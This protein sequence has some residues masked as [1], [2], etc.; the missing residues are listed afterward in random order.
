MHRD[1]ATWL[2]YW[3]ENVMGGT[4]YVF[5][6]ASSGFKGKSD[7]TKYEKARKLCKYIDKIRS[8]YIRNLDARELEQAC[9]A[10][11]DRLMRC[12]GWAAHAHPRAPA[13]SRRRCGSSTSW[14]S[15]WGTR[16]TRMRRTPSAPAPSASSTLPFSRPAP[17]SS[18]S[19]ARTPCA[20]TSALTCVQP[21]G[22]QAGGPV[23]PFPSPPP[24]SPQLSTYSPVGEK[25]FRNLKRFC[26]K[27]PAKAEIF[28]L[29]TVDMLNK[30]LSS[31]MPGLSGKVFRTYNAS[32]TLEQQLAEHAEEIKRAATSQEQKRVYDAANREVAIL[33]NH[34]RTVPKTHAA[35]VEKLQ[36]KVCARAHCAAFCADSG[37]AR[38]LPVQLDLLEEQL[39]E[40]QTIQKAV[41]RGKQVK[42]KKAKAEGEEV[43]RE[44]RAKEAH[45]F[46]R[47]PSVEQVSNKIA[48]WHKKIATT[49]SQ[50]MHK[51]RA[52]SPPPCRGRVRS[53]GADACG[54]VPR[55]KTRRWR[56]AHPRSTTWTP[57]SRWRGA[58]PMRCRW[59][60]SSPPL[61]ATSLAGPCPSIPHG[62][63][64]RSR[65]PWVGA[66]R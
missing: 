49:S 39:A 58:R 28:D 3:N 10:G 40:L 27:K 63:S 35:Q 38:L 15:V 52:A 17:S 7:Q 14:P 62:A 45:L 9:V 23:T 24:T 6:A 32:V 59:S 21:G 44:E 31:L 12:A 46:A 37:P 47:Q 13:N 65:Y 43:T 16:R 36:T 51:V 30:H 33:C 48:Q 34:Q 60:A 4:K 8:D 61:C 29:L 20:T 41:K 26:S 66:G 53:P 54:P 64:R 57:G 1:D 56:S 50:L 42:T 11:P 22:C 19:W 5:L 18:T 2:A 55:R 25:V